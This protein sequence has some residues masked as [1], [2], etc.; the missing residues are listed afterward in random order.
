MF[1]GLFLFLR[2]AGNLRNRGQIS[3]PQTR[4]TR[5][6]QRDI[7]ER[8]EKIEGLLTSTMSRPLDFQEACRYLKI[9]ASRLYNLTSTG[10]ISHYKLGGGKLLRF[11][12]EDLNAFLMLKRIPSVLEKR[13]HG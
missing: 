3:E 10:Q 4:G 6:K 7:E 13:S 2:L 12:I 8:L 9:S 11:T 1:L 5:V